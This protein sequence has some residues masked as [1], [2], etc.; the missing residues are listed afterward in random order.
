MPVQLL[1]HIDN[2]P[3]LVQWGRQPTLHTQLSKDFSCP[4][5]GKFHFF[6]N[7]DVKRHAATV[8]MRSTVGFAPNNRCGRHVGI[9]VLHCPVCDEQFTL[10][11]Q[12]QVL[13]AYA[14]GCVFWPKPDYPQFVNALLRSELADWCASFQ[15]AFRRAVFLLP[16]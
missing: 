8:W 7:G 10:L 6:C 13:E 11:L 16:A 4:H 5:C 3:Y 12:R 15:Y 1:G 14:L 9:A 2:T